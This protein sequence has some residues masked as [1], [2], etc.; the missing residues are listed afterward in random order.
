MQHKNGEHPFGD[1]GQ[2]AACILFIIIW[3]TDSFFLQSSRFLTERIPL[4]P[5]LLIM[6]LL[7]IPAIWICGQSHKS[8]DRLRNMNRLI[9]NGVYRYIR[10]PLYLSCLMVYSGLAV[11]TLSAGA[12]FVWIGIFLFYD[13]IASYEEKI[14]SA[15]F[16]NAYRLYMNKTGKWL[17]RFIHPHNA[18]DT[19]SAAYRT[20]QGNRTQ[21]HE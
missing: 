2:V 21:D 10:H 8:M 17:P 11:S 18:A 9:T 1:A 19:E 14:L 20:F 4:L 5:R 12:L 6:G 13:Y 7:I 16:G 15:K 3:S